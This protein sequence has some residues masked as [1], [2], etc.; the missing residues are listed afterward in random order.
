MAGW[1]LAL[2]GVASIVPDLYTILRW[3]AL[4]LW[5]HL[6]WRVKKLLSL[7]DRGLAI[8]AK[9]HLYTV[10]MILTE[11]L[12]SITVHSMYVLVI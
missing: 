3:L 4:H 7:E 1:I 10:V 5:L 6:T 9:A 11:G 8:C 2:K 12:G